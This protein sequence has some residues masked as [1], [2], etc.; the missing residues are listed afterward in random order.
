MGSQSAEGI[1]TGE[2]EIDNEKRQDLF[3]PAFEFCRAFFFLNFILT[4]PEGGGL[5]KTSLLF[6]NLD[7]KEKKI[8]HVELI[9][10]IEPPPVHHRPSVNPCRRLSPFRKEPHHLITI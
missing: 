5:K 4:F 7:S 8:L 9:S 1:L 3:D 6:I 10:E 2:N